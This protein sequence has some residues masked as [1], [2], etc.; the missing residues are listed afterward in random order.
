MRRFEKFE[1]A[2]FDEGN[3]TARELDFEAGTVMGCPKENGLGFQ[4]NSSFSRFENPFDD[5]AGLCGV[6]RNI[7]EVRLFRRRAV[8]P[9]VFGEALGGE[10][11]D[12]VS[13]SKYRLCRSVIALQRYDFR[14]WTEMAGE[15]EDVAHGRR[16]KGIDRLRV[17]ADNRQTAPGGLQGQ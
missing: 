14:L 16:P 13:R 6:V 17:V 4:N 9:E 10:L 8:R 11:D 5:I 3:I 15:I 12:G 7:D 2:E 1:A